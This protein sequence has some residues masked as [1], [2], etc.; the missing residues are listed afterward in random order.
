VLGAVFH[1]D[2]SRLR[3]GAGPPNMATVRHMA[4]NLLRA[5]KYKHSIKARRKYAT[6][7]TQYR[8]A[9]LRQSA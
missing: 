2:L 9:L 1:A 7:D 6:S 4:M 5:P 8:K 3:S